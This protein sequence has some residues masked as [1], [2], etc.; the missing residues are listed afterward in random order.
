MHLGTSPTNKLDTK[1]QLSQAFTSNFRVILILFCD[2][3]PETYQ[4]PS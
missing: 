3:H 1:E 4:P 2:S